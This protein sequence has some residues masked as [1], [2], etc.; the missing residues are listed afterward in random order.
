MCEGL[1]RTID[2]IK[3][4]PFHIYLS[5]VFQAYYSTRD[6][7]VDADKTQQNI[8]V[9]SGVWGGG[10]GGVLATP[11]SSKYS[12]AHTHILHSSRTWLLQ[13]RLEEVRIPLLRGAQDIG[14]M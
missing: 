7:E 12:Q 13:Q 4:P 2:R 3:R 9:A 1:M 11:P 6:A 8:S 10:G 5:I 14:T